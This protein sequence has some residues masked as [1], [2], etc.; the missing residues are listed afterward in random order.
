MHPSAPPPSVPQNSGSP[1]YPPFGAAYQAYQPVTGAAPPVGVA[2]GGKWPPGP[3][4]VGAGGN[5]EAE[6]GEGFYR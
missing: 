5:R 2:Q 4:A 6:G 1:V 3:A